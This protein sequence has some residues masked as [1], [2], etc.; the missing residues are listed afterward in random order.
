[1]KEKHAK[2]AVTVKSKAE[3]CSSKSTEATGL[4][5]VLTL[6]YNCTAKKLQ[7]AD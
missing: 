4:R 1:M 2:H 7:F 6:L 5:K 3:L